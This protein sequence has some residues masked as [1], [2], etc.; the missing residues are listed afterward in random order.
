MPM[1]TLAPRDLASPW[2]LQISE[3]EGYFVKSSNHLEIHFNAVYVMGCPKNT[4]TGL[5]GLFNFQ[6]HE[7]DRILFSSLP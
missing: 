5:E 1:K 2:T 6:V 7:A 3:K 4:S